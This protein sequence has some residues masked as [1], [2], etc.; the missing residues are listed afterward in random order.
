MR[1]RILLSTVVPLLLGLV[2][3]VGV[4][5]NAYADAEADA[6]TDADAKMP[7]IH[8]ALSGAT[9]FRLGK[10]IAK[11][12]LAAGAIADVSAFPPDQ[13]LVTGKQIGQTTASVWTKD[14]E[15]T[16][17]SIV[18]GYATDE[19]LVSLKR[20]LPRAKN[21]RVESAG[22]ALLLSGEVAD[23]TEVVRAEEIVRSYADAASSSGGAV[24]PRILNALTVPGD[25]Q[26]Q[27]EVSFAEVS[28]TAL[29]QVGL[30]VWHRA[31]NG[32]YATQLVPPALSSDPAGAA[33]PDLGLTNVPVMATPIS[34]AFGV[35]FSSAAGTSFPFSAALSLLAQR[36]YARTLSEPTLVALSGE[37]AIFL[38]GGEFP[39]S[40]PQGLGQTSIEFKKF[41]VQ[42]KFTPTIVHDTIQLRLAATVS[43]IDF[44]LGLRLA[45]VQVPGLTTRHSETTVRLRDGQSFAIAGLLSDRVR[46]TVD[47]VPLLGELPILG[48][49]FR[50]T[51]YR[52]EETELLIVVTARLVRPQ[53]ERPPL[54]D[55]ERST[56]PSDLEL[57]L[58]GTYESKQNPKAVGTP[59]GPVGFAR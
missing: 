44:S 26:V 1:S 16:I 37:D 39:V 41:G 8:V 2:A 7:V 17:V 34:G 46:S 52:R 22:A 40:V 28:R 19:M 30:N 47:K 14:D 31:T 50:S 9:H 18:V 27:L 56:D 12:S 53:A 32:D 29:R 58:L 23:V 59:A 5:R 57:F 49:L 48:V 25:Q 54:P 6:E 55:G 36:G 21:L 10:S 43:D 38:A 35:L 3:L 15:I 20:A 45:S 11:I 13:L 51:S 33:G 24:A 4:G 42:L